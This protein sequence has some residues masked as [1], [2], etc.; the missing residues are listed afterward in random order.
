M[1]I[2]EWQE[3]FRIDIELFDDHHQQLVE[4]LNS[5]YDNLAKGLSAEEIATILDALVEYA[6]YHFEAEE[7][8]MLANSYPYLGMHV[9]EH[10]GFRANVAEMRSNYGEGKETILA[11]LNFL[12][13]WLSKHILITDADLGRFSRL[14]I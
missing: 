10:A 8:W 3:T 9:S 11:I 13:D 1:P 6:D 7:Q 12:V 5:T 14:K 2:M 4:L